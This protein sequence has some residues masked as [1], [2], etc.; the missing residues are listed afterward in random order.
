[1]QQYAGTYLCSS[2]Q[3]HM[4]AVVCGHICSSTCCDSVGVE[5]NGQGAVGV[6]ELALASFSH[7]PPA[8]GCLDFCLK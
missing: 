8:E 1:M 4:Y 6:L 7:P 3:T 2:M 5:P